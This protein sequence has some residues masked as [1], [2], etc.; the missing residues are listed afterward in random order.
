MNQTTGEKKDLGQLNSHTAPSISTNSK[1]ENQK[2]E[3]D[4]FH[5]RSR[6]SLVLSNE[7]QSDAA[8]SEFAKSNWRPGE[9]KLQG[10][11]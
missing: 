9:V 8:V 6:C 5:I 1:V 3:I 2:S 4:I 11:E 10:G 7:A